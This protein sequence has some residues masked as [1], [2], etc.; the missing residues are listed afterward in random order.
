MAIDPKKYT[1]A[2]LAKM[3]E[4]A[5]KAQNDAEI[6]A[7]ERLAKSEDMEG[8][9]GELEA[10]TR[11]LK[12]RNIVLTESIEQMN[13]EAVN[14]A[15]E[16]ARLR[17]DADALRTKLADTEAVLGRMNADASRLTH[18]L[19][20]AKKVGAQYA[21]AVKFASDHPF[22]VLWIWVKRKLGCA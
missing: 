12:Q 2:E 4:D 8:K 14:K 11:M 17:S 16:I 3:V 20:V 22:T 7:A 6:A 5:L 15:N 9:N 19:A 21:A 1:R 13:G 10:Q 18:D